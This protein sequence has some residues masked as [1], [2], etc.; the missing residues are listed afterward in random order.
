[1]SGIFSLKFENHSVEDNFDK[2]WL[3]LEKVGSIK[4]K[5]TKFSL[6]NDE[7][8]LIEYQLNNIPAHPTGFRF[9]SK[10]SRQ[11]NLLYR[12]EGVLGWIWEKIKAFFKWIKE[13]FMKL[14]GVD[15]KDTDAKLNEVKSTLKENTANYVAIKPLSE[16]VSEQAK[17]ITKVDY[18]LPDG[19][20][21]KDFKK[22][23]SAV[24]MVMDIKKITLKTFRELAGPSVSF[25]SESEFK[26]SLSNLAS[27]GADYRT[28][29]SSFDSGI[30]NFKKP[31]LKEALV[32]FAYNLDGVLGLAEMFEFKKELT[33]DF[34]P[35]QTSFLFCGASKIIL[36]AFSVEK[37]KIFKKTINA[38]AG[39]ETKEPTDKEF[40]EAFDKFID[41]GSF[42]EVLKTCESFKEL[43]AVYEKNFIGMVNEAEADFEANHKE[44]TEE[45]KKMFEALKVYLSAMLEFGAGFNAFYANL[46]HFLSRVNVSLG[47][48]TSDISKK[49]IEQ[50]LDDSDVPTIII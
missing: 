6:P 32:P 9:E 47:R 40:L 21:V 17:K 45:S 24:K 37:E 22:S 16:K 33:G 31:T 13:Q 12:T 19:S 49:D 41:S 39:S 35:N 18:K 44:P 50:M 43:S 14:F 1:M 25:K 3:H 20:I 8:S 15:T 36:L 26:R 48:V 42:D 5:L 2:L 11:A 4:E 10:A 34:S 23:P 28:V 27:I 29:L 38:L 30:N 7:L 46:V